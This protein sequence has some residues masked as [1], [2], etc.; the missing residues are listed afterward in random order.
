MR[1]PFLLEIIIIIN[2]LIHWRLFHLAHL[3]ELKKKLIKFDKNG[4][5]HI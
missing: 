2:F 1:I 3:L 5:V 4:R